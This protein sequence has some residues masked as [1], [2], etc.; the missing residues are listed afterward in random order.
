MDESPASSITRPRGFR[1]AGVACG[2]KQSGRP[3]VAMI[4]ADT[5]CA[6]AGVFTTNQIKGAPVVVGMR[7]LEERDHLQAIVCNSG[8]SNV[9]TGERGLADA[10][11]MCEV[12]AEAVGCDAEEVLPASTG[13]IGRPLPMGKVERGIA[14]AA[15]SLGTGPEHDTA[16]A[17]AI[18][19]TDLTVKAAVREIELDGRPVTLAGI[20]KGSGMIAPSMATMLAFLTTDAAIAPGP[21]RSALRRACAGSFNRISVDTDTSTSDTAYLLASGRAGNDTVSIDRGEA[22]SMFLG[23]LTDLCRDLAYRIIKD[24]EG[25]TRVFRVVVQGAADEADADRVG[26]AVSDSPLVKCA[27]HGKDPNWGRLVMAVGKSGARLDPE[28]LRVS[29]GDV[30]VFENTMPIDMTDA[31]ERQLETI[32]G[33]DEVTFTIDLG[34]GD[35]GCTW[36]GCDLSRDYIGINA[37]YRT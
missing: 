36:Y 3:D 2:I 17:Q 5:P 1:A 22:F 12:A 26:R 27:V 14:D 31:V 16:C 24:G 8:N 37:D 7:R 35:A 18:L 20:A 23:A 11:R 9:A 33:G 34:L 21:L 10:R 30:A 4:V 6:A 28:Q 25:A 15:A 29:I 13:I 32:M 19:T